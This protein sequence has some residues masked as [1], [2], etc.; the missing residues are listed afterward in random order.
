M[1]IIELLNKSLEEKDFSYVEEALYVLTGV[2]Q[3]VK[4]KKNKIEVKTNKHKEE[5]T[6]NS[7]VDDLGL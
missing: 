6:L 1:T 2:R 7:F 5:D 4:N 3:K